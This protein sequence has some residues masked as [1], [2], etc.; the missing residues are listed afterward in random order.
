[1]KE[2]PNLSNKDIND[3]KALNNSFD[4]LVGE[5]SHSLSGFD[6]SKLNELDKVERKV[7]GLLYGEVKSISNFTGD[8][9]SKVLVKLFN[10][11]DNNDNKKIVPQG[12]TIDNLFQA[13]NA[14]IMQFMQDRYRNRFYLYD[15]LNMVCNQ[16]FELKEAVNT[17]RDAICTADD[18]G[19]QI[20]KTIK[21]QGID[22]K[23]SQEA[24]STIEVLEKSLKLETK[25]KNHIIPKT[26]T[27]GNYFVYTIPYAQ[28]LSKYADKNYREK[29]NKYNGNITD[30]SSIKIESVCE[31]TMSEEVFMENFKNDL[32]MDMSKEEQEII[33]ENMN[34]TIKHFEIVQGDYPLPL[35]ENAKFDPETLF[36]ADSFEKIV[37]AS[38]RLNET[39]NS[40]YS[41]GTFATNSESSSDKGAENTKGVYIKLLNPKY[42]LPL[43]I[44]NNTT[45][46]YYYML[47]DKNDVFQGP[48][49]TNNL[50]PTFSTFGN[51]D[52]TKESLEKKMVGKI[53]DRIVKNFDHKKFI[54][55]NQQFK[56]MV[57]DA[58]LFNDMY[59]KN[60]KFIFIPAEYITEFKVNEDEEGNGT[61]I[62]TDSLFYAKL[63]L[64]LLLF[65]MLTVLTKSNDTRMY[66]IKNGSIDKDIANQVQQ[67]ARSIKSR[68]INF[69]DLMNCNAMV[70]KIGANREVFIP[71][72]RT[73]DRSIEFDIL[74]GQDVQ[75][76]TEMM[77]KLRINFINSTGIPS[78]MMNYINEADYAKTLVMANAKMVTR[79]INHQRDFNYSLT[80]LYKKILLYATDLPSD[81]IANLIYEL[82]S[83]KNL[84]E[85]NSADLINSVEA[86]ATFMMDTEFGKEGDLNDEERLAKDITYKQLIKE[87]TPQFPWANMET[88]ILQ[89]KLEAK[90]RM[91]AKKGNEQEEMQ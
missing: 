17:M 53:V 14:E 25:I 28:I 39:K 85:N 54:E 67:V 7:D 12:K 90:K 82:N 60:I 48:T 49:L 6:V 32:D 51:K 9:I 42:T 27:Y 30:T 20:S 77:E 19:T 31:A 36:A 66:Y 21:F 52:G 2:K 10:E 59:R 72:S 88:K 44:M 78:V 47:E 29:D 55:E 18:V 34:N 62:L 16:L 1:M 81:I 86:R 91:Q 76:D 65:K 3:I 41:D 26:L 33:M 4:N 15:D 80:E 68:Q 74:A 57:V 23:D 69:T 73:G 87:M 83:P 24:L 79:T 22:S 56:Q 37:K 64:A 75:F 89:A 40:Q 5:I 43:Q 58:L 70:S 35:Y 50:S 84:Q 13:D 8:E 45:I 46:G 11:Y 71:V 63:Y 38:G 61:S